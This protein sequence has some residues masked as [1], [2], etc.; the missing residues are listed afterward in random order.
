M[1]LAVLFFGLLFKTL[2]GSVRRVEF[3]FAPGSP[4]LSFQSVE[5]VGKDS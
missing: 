3:H 1:N 2:G 4:S 5:P